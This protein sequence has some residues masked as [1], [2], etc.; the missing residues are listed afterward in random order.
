MTET[1]IKMRYTLQDGLVEGVNEWEGQVFTT[2]PGCNS[3]TG[4]II[5]HVPIFADFAFGTAPANPLDFGAALADADRDVTA[6][7]I[8]IGARQGTT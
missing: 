3:S 5:E 4:K 6:P 7:A 2:S 8:A 1:A